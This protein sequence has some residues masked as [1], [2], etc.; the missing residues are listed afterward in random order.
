VTITAKAKAAGTRRGRRKGQAE[1]FGRD[2]KL[3]NREA[4]GR[5]QPVQTPQKRALPALA[6]TCTQHAHFHPVI[7]IFLVNVVSSAMVLSQVFPCLVF[8][9]KP[10]LPKMPN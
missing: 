2:A 9:L 8:C 10:H 4:A 6:A 3:R 7:F 1:E 5:I